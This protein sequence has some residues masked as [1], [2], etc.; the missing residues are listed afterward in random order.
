MANDNTDDATGPDASPGPAMRP[1][2]SAPRVTTRTPP[3]IEGKA[4]ELAPP[5]PATPDPTM[6]AT[7]AQ[8][9][10]AH[11]AVAHETVAHETAAPE[12]ATHGAPWGGGA[13][14]VPEQAAKDAAKDADAEATPEAVFDSTI[15]VEAE[16]VETRRKSGRMGAVLALIVLALFGVGAW[17]AWDS[18]T[19]GFSSDLPGLRAFFGDDKPATIARATA[20]ATSPSSAAKPSPTAS[21]P[22]ASAT[23]TSA[24]SALSAPSSSA[25]PVPAPGASP[26]AAPTPPKTPPASAP[27]AP[28]S[29]ATAPPASTSAASSASAPIAAPAK[30]SPVAPGALP[31]S[32]PPPTA[33][34]VLPPPVVTDEGRVAA[35][36]RRVSALDDRIAALTA[37]AKPTSDVSA[38]LSA[39]L[40][41]LDAKLSALDSRLG[42]LDGKLAALDKRVSDLDT[43]ISAPKVDARVPES[44][45]VMAGQQ[46][47][48]LAARSVVAQSLVN[49]LQT[50]APFA[51]EITAL[52]TLGVGDDR[53]AKLDA[54]S[55]TGLPTIAKLRDAFAAVRPKLVSVARSDS[56]ASWS[57][58][59]AARFS[60]LV[61]IRP[62]TEKAG[63]SP[64]AIASRI[65]AALQRGDLAAAMSEYSTLSDAD[66]ANAK[67]WYDL[68]SQR[69]VAEASARAILADTIAALGKPKS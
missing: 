65:D 66:K 68:A 8:E 30:P 40:A 24:S 61:T 20:P 37:T 9:T 12:A 69:V 58:R 19:G 34:S 36:D 15:P 31:S 18:Q 32:A 47:D 52:R 1:A 35:I 42:A 2:G 57:D 14:G 64:E 43:K 27:S 59:L 49:A 23:G 44:R 33:S 22:P 55:K 25:P 17:L 45:D 39:R 51:P 26:S 4:E 63:P 6:H 11:E 62:M 3:T 46:A 60:G 16:A 28:A 29:S 21:A 41:P 7:V 48:Q 5:T 56:G 10:A 13:F 38:D 53:L 54:V 50:G 67:P